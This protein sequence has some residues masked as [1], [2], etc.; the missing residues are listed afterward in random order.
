[1]TH[2]ASLRYKK[3]AHPTRGSCSQGTL[4]FHP[5]PHALMD[6]RHLRLLRRVRRRV[7]N[8]K[9]RGDKCMGRSTACM[10][11]PGLAEHGGKPLRAVGLGERYKTRPRPLQPFPSA[12]ATRLL[13]VGPQQRSTHFVLPQHRRRCRRHHRL[14]EVA[15]RIP[16]RTS[17]MMSCVASVRP[18]STSAVGIR[19]RATALAKG[20]IVWMRGRKLKTVALLIIM[21]DAMAPLMTSAHQTL[22]ASVLLHR[23]RQRRR[24]GRQLRP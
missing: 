9:R 19:A 10:I 6:S 1:M 14:L 3:S 24:R 11:R 12:T 15:I 4:I 13:A 17:I 16:G 22:Y 8:L 2:A 5:V 23:R 21:L 18:W 7:R 20:W